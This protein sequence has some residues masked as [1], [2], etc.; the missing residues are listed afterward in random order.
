MNNFKSCIMNPDGETASFGS[1]VTIKEAGEF[2]LQHGRAL[3]TTP[4]FGGITIG[5]A[6]GTGAHGSS[7]KYTSSISSQVVRMTAVNGLGEK[8]EIVDPEDLKSF[9]VHLGLLGIVVDVT[10]K[11]VP[12][13]KV[14][15]T[16]YIV[17]DE[18][19]TNGKALE[20]A[21]TTDQITFYWF[22]AFKEVVVANLT[23]V[24][25][26]ETGNAYTNAI[27]PPTY[28]YFNLGGTKAKEI[29]FDLSTSECALASG[30]GN[31][32]LHAFEIAAQSS[33]V[34][35]TPG[36]VP[37]YT[38]DGITVEN[39]AV[40]FPHS[41]FAASCSEANAGLGGPSCFW[42]H[43]DINSNIT[44][45]DNEFCIDIN[46]LSDFVETTQDIMKTTPVAFPLTGI[47]IRFS[48]E[49]DAYMATNFGRDTAHVEF[50]MWKRTDSYNKASGNL[51]GYQLLAQALAK[52]FKGRSHWGKSGLVYHG[53]EMLD[54]KL[55]TEAR[56]SFI[57]SMKKFDPNE[58][59]MN[60]FG[61][62]IVKRD[63]KIDSDPKSTRC[64]LLDNCFCSQNKDCI[65]TQTCTKLSGYPDYP[66][67]KTKNEV[68]EVHL[69]KSAF[70]PPAGIFNWLVVSVPNLVIPVLAQCPPTGLLN[71]VPNLV[72]SILG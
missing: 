7:I 33:L 31:T 20:W 45:V 5:G 46:S 3:R 25:V 61:R 54:I 47:F 32:I 13:Y 43:G 52:K 21:K 63:T 6:I 42:A 72:G 67:C 55:E 15:A 70:P 12:L 41:M 9:K 49:S 39:P 68:P 26:D 71:T 53:R 1:G 16:N 48:G 38:E 14:L 4:A 22:P 29:A 66:V 65:S 23:F 8:V 18:I 51:A 56:D 44:I 59:F 60:S 50:A 35:D 27:S 2:L 40:G 28:G 30:V 62:R 58:R 37:I 69:D 36:F 19:L 10:L 57:A 11:T 34:R 64:A 17:S 24:S